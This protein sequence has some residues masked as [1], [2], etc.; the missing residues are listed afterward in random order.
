MG[1]ALR[2]TVLVIGVI[3]PGVAAS[4]EC[5]EPPKQLS[6]SIE[7]DATVTVKALR[8]WLGEAGLRNQTEIGINNLYQKYPN[9]DRLI[10][11][12]LLVS[13][14]CTMLADASDLTTEERFKLYAETRDRI[15]T[16]V[17]PAME[18]NSNAPS[19]RVTYYRMAGVAPSFLIKG[20]LAPEWEQALGGPQTIIK[21]VVL[22]EAKSFLE[23]F[24]R[25][26]QATLSMGNIH[27]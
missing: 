4:L 20:L 16:L 15:L 11:A 26:L 5:A 18:P 23:R 25:T 24:P 10:L 19:F 13:L 6:S 12:Q 3:L 2:A 17:T 14:F 8:R 21:N 27:P 22:L 7:N 9:A 1:Q